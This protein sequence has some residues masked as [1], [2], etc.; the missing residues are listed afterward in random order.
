MTIKQS[1]SNTFF[2]FILGKIKRFPARLNVAEK[3]GYSYALAIGIAILGTSAGLVVG[4]YYQQ[5]ALERLALAETQEDLLSHLE[6][7]VLKMRSHP[8]ELLPSLGS[9]I[10]FD[11]AKAHFYVSSN[12]VKSDL[13]ELNDFITENPKFVLLNPNYFNE[14]LQNYDRATSTYI[15]LIETLWQQVNPDQI[16]NI[17]A[18]QK[19]IVSFL[20]QEKATKLNLELN[21]LSEDL[22]VL[23]SAAESRENIATTNHFS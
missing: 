16:T 14:I 22:A 11:Y 4:E 21:R 9:F 23:L 2:R 19:S 5:R 15:Q 7:S 20:N 1:L 8:Q 10:L 6:N 12:Q 17:P 18:A 3:F 13:K